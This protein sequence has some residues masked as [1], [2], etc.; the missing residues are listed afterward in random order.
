VFAR[1]GVPVKVKIYYLQYKLIGMPQSEV[2]EFENEGSQ[3]TM[4]GKLHMQL[5][6]LTEEVKTWEEEKD[7]P[8]SSSS[9]QPA[10]D[11]ESRLRDVTT[12]NEEL[13]KRLADYERR[14]SGT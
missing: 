5:G 2:L 8:G 7:V 9:S 14:G 12:E 11:P 6:G 1:N 13:R 3:K 4:A 10:P